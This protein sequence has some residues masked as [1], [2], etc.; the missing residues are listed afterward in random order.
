MDA[1][2][3]RYAIEHPG[4][5]SWWAMYVTG[6]VGTTLFLWFGWKLYKERGK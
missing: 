4:S 5:F 6:I 3:V 1:E 2:W